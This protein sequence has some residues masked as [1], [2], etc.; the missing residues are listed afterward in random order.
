MNATALDKPA[1]LTLWPAHSPKHVATGRS[2]DTLREALAVAV[3]AIRSEDARP[4]I[5][6]EEGDILAPSWISANAAGQRLQ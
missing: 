2:F 1:D 3:A 4:W 5:I 6:T